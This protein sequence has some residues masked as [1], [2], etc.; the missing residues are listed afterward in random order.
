M[1]HPASSHADYGPNE[2]DDGIVIFKINVPDRNQDQNPNC[3][4]YPLFSIY[5][6]HL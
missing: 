3:R 6:W 2:R 5:S 1:E 4:K